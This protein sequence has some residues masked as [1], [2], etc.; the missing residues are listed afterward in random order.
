MLLSSFF[1]YVK[2]QLLPHLELTTQLR[3]KVSDNLLLIGCD[4]EKFIPTIPTTP[5]KTPLGPDIAAV[6]VWAVFVWAGTV[7]MVDA[8]LGPVIFNFDAWE[9]TTDIP[10][11]GIAKAGAGI[12]VIVTDT[13][14]A[15]TVTIILKV[16]VDGN[17]V[18]CGRCFNAAL[19]CQYHQRCCHWWWCYFSSRYGGYA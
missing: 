10:T 6:F 7:A 4:F 8:A 9:S 14:F 16:F 17:V 15:L 13:E 5:M 18:C 2:Q 12:S 3:A 19:S 1:F 11:P